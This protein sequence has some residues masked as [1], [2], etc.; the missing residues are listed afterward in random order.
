MYVDLK[1][2]IYEF[3]SDVKL[4]CLVDV[5]VLFWTSFRF[6][7][8]SSFFGVFA[9]FSLGVLMTETKMTHPS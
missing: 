2:L 3:N 8:R 9:V 5:V 4:T 6:V 7:F 1:D